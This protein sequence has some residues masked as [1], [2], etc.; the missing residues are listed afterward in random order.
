M[1]HIVLGIDPDA[2]RAGAV[3]AGHQP[4]VVDAGRRTRSRRLPG[5]RVYVG[6]ASPATSAPTPPAAILAEGPHRSEHMQLLVD[7]GTNAE[8][9]LGDRT[10]QFAAS[11][12]TGPAFEGAQISCGQR[13]TAGAIEGVRID[14]RHARAAAQG[15]RCRR[16]VGRS[17]V[18]AA[19]AK[20]GVT[21]IC[22]SGIIDVDRRDVSRR[23]DRARRCRSQ[24]ELAA[25]STRIVADGRTFSYVLCGD[26]DD[27]ADRG[28][29]ERRP[30]D[31]A[32]QGGAARR[33]RPADRARRS[34]DRRPTSASP[35]RSAPTSTQCTRWCSGSCPTARSTE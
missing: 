24:G 15:D 18:H 35:A 31:P 26:R 27:A 5:A 8:I 29:T 28:H 7:V 20:T 3:H 1:H 16:V 21:G 19:V 12:P 33:H 13:A 9:V 10:R 11:S 6:R 14:P 30:R 17:G 22:G 23:C 25:R 34:A 2:A 32:R 4:G